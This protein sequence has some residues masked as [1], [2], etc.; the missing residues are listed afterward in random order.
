MWKI[1]EKEW[2]ESPLIGVSESPISGGRLS[3]DIE[4]QGADVVNEKLCRNRR[5]KKE[6][7]RNLYDG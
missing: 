6:T 3:I 4:L 5:C 2:I 1:N 7:R